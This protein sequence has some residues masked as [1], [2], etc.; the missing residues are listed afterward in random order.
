MVDAWP[1]LDLSQAAVHE[2]L[3]AGYIS[4][5]IG[6]QEEITFATVRFGAD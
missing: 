2:Q 4:A 1:E 3:D 5:V 6:S